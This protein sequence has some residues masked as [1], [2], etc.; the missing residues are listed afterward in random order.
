MIEI[1][2]DTNSLDKAAQSI[3]ATKLQTKKAFSGALLDTGKAGAIFVKKSVSRKVKVPQKRLGVRIQTKRDPKTGDVVLWI[4]T[5]RISV[6]SLGSIRSSRSGVSV[7]RIQ[8]RGAFLGHFAGGGGKVFI[9]EKSIHFQPDL[10]GSVSYGG[11][12]LRSRYG[13][14]KSRFPLRLAMIKIDDEAGEA[15]D[16]FFA[17]AEDVLKENFH[18]RLNFEVN[19]KK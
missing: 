4:G 16:A 6:H 8:R 7:G 1:S 10:Y 9:R 19:V 12:H 15:A 5:N 3:G 2:I 13:S 18:R 14:V 11:E 17:G